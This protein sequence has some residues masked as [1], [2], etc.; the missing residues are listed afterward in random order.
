MILFCFS[1]KRDFFCFFKMKLFH[2]HHQPLLVIISFILWRRERTKRHPPSPR[3]LPIWRGCNTE[4][5]RNRRFSSVL[6]SRDA[7]WYFWTAGALRITLSIIYTI[8]LTPQGLGCETPR[9]LI[10]LQIYLTNLKQFFYCIVLWF[11]RLEDHIGEWGS[12]L[13]TKY[14]ITHY[15]L[16]TEL[17]QLRFPLK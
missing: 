13:L 10:F 11:K 5:R 4:N 7:R 9:L 16:P 6:V 3:P 14:L 15:G 2:Q 17:Y 8:E 12:P 1:F